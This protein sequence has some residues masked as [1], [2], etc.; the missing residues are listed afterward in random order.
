[1][2]V[3]VGGGLLGRVIDPLGNPLD[4]KDSIAAEKRL[5]IECPAAPIMDR[6]AVASSLLTHSSRSWKP[7][8]YLEPDLMTQR[9]RRLTMDS[10]FAPASSN[11]SLN[12]F[13]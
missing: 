13:P 6:V 7:L 4:G 2:D 8:R 11:P 9:K 1:M 12:P 10:V 5:P 3:F